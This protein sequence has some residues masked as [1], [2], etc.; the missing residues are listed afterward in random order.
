MILIWDLLCGKWVPYTN[1]LALYVLPLDPSIMHDEF[2]ERT[3]RV[4]QERAGNRCSNPECSVL[5]SGPNAHPE[6][7]TKTGVAVHISAASPGG[8]RYNPHLTP[9]QRQSAE[10]GIWLCQNCA[11]FVDTDY[12]NF[13]NRG[14]QYQL[15]GR[16]LMPKKPGRKRKEK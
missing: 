15:I 3:K 16:D 4:I 11:H 8:P 2:S 6:R 7:S 10:N 1:K 9:A 13:L 14:T 5:T 12:L